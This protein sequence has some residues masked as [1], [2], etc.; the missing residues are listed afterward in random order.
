MKRILLSFAAVFAVATINAQVDTLT[1]WFTGTPTVYSAGAGNG[2]VFG[3]NTYGDK[4]KFQRFDA[5]NGISGTGT[6]TGALVWVSQ[7]SD[8]GGSFDVTV[9]DFT[10]GTAGSILGSS[11]VTLASVDTTLAGTMVAEGAVGYNVAVTF[12][13]AIAVSSTS[14]ILVGITLPTTAAAGDTV[15]MVSNTDGDYTAANTHSWEQA[16]DDSW[17]DMNTDWGGADFAMA[18]YPTVDLTPSNASV[19]ENSIEVSVYPNPTSSVLNIKTSEAVSTVSIISTDGKI[20]ST[21]EMNGTTGSVNVA[22]LNAGV[23]FYEVSTE[24]GNVVRNTFIK[25]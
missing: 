18:I 16:S 2:Y 20:L 24:S 15:V 14:D 8:A 11:T 21:T 4:G 5:S 6:L 3:N 7:K 19:V 12:S 22:E 17:G 1:E 13:P 23:Y 25:K 9:Y 10:G